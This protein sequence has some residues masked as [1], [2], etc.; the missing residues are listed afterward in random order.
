M[1]MAEMC[2]RRAAPAHSTSECLPVDVQTDTAQIDLCRDRVEHER[3]VWSGECPS[4]KVSV[5]FFVI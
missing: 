1:E 4:V 2:T 5:G 3:I